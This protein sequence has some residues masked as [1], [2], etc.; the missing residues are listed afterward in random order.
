VFIGILLTALLPA[1]VQTPAPARSLAIVN[2]TLHEFEDGQPI[3]SGHAF[4]A[5]E[6]VFF[7]MQVRGYQ[8]APDQKIRL[9]Y[10]ID[11]LD[12]DG[13]LLAET[14][15]GK[16]E[17]ESSYEDRDWLPKIRHSFLIPPHALSGQFR[18][19]AWVKDEISGQ[20]QKAEVAF[21]V[22]GHQVDTS[23]TLTLRNF[24]FLRAEEDRE[25]RAGA[26]YKPGDTLWARFDITGFKT[27]EKNHIR[28]VY[29]I[30]IVGASGKV[31][32]SNTQAAAE[33][34]TPFY[35]RR[36]LPEIMSLNVQ[37]KTTAGEYTLVVSVRDEAGQ[38][39]FESRQTFRV[40]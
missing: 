2:A 29:G 28:V 26:S 38:Q 21:Q 30:S 37:P 6:T 32:L 8:V 40:E 4:V 23:G 18:I 34:D 13:A 39:T 36:Y 12:S 33:E 15:A 9:T 19:S 27:G 24:R 7:S 10:R 22:L 11:A 31:L 5:G 3:P 25:P 20:D 1:V 14:S 17:T 35:P 16:V